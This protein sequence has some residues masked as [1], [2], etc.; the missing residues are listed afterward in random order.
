L[1]KKARIKF[2]WHIDPIQLGAQF[3]KANEVKDLPR[4]IEDIPENKRRNN[5]SSML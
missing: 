4:L 5:F 1:I 2:D 3:L